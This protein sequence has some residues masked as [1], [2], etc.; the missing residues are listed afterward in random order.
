MSDSVHVFGDDALAE[1]DAVQLAALLRRAQLAPHEVAEAAVA[2][3]RAADEQLAAVQFPLYE[4]AL[5][6]ARR[7]TLDGPFAGVPSLVKDNVAYQ[8]TPTGL[9]SSAFTPRMAKQHSAVVRQFLSTGVTVLGKTR[10]PEFGFNASTEFATAPPVRN[11]WHT[12]YSAGGSSGGSA[13]LVAAGAVPLAHGNDG[14]G[15][16]RIPAACCGLVALKATRGRMAP[17][18]QAR[19]L[20]HDLVSDGVL[21]RTVRD[22]AAFYAAAERHRRNPKLPPLGRVE[23]PPER[24]LT[25]GLLWDSP[26]GAVTDAQTRAAVSETAGALEG[27]GHTVEPVR[28]LLDGRFE[29]DFLTYWGML[30]FLTAAAGRLRYGRT[31]ERR[32]M[33]AFSNGLQRFFRERL[34]QTPGALRRL[35]AIGAA[36]DAVFDRH[37]LVLSPVLAHTTPQLGHLSPR[38]PFETVIARLTSYVA[39]TP[40][41]N[42]T[43]TPALSLPGGTTADGLPVGVMLSARG[44][45]ERTLLEVAYLLESLRPWRRHA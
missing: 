32:R 16:L 10:L 24:R 1:H 6:A 45:D 27:A 33:D 12:A 42:V 36:Y 5:R 19:L 3:V 17:N 31:F 18:D 11:P 30:S 4:S 29:Q 25:I 44:G 13:A 21:S 15:S 14:G 38:E 2:R 39:F 34:A 23:G 8:G 7:S 41:N 40:L 43:G 37:D 28:L 26:T 20:P 22:S 9:G 35:R